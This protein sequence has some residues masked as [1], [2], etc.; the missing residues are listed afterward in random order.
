MGL[1]PHGSR[2]PFTEPPC[3]GPAWGAQFQGGSAV[4]S[5]LSHSPSALSVPG[6]C[7]TQLRTRQKT[8][9]APESVSA[10]ELRYPQPSLP[11][12][13]VLLLHSW[14]PPLWCLLDNLLFLAL[15]SADFWKFVKT[16]EWEKITIAAIDSM[17]CCDSCNAEACAAV[18]D[19]LAQTETSSLKHVSS[20]SQGSSLW[21]L[22]APTSWVRR[23]SKSSLGQHT[24]VG[25][26]AT[27]CRSC[28]YGSLWQQSSSSPT[29]PPGANHCEVHPPV[30]CVQQGCVC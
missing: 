11:G 20:C 25:S 23:A 13:D 29:S 26:K 15:P 22:C 9:S 5:S 12:L 21:G 14:A 2:A 18:L 19:L 27:L 16:D 17:V 4:F 28:G 10:I 7:Q 1:I 30:A 6:L 3:A 24:V 8:G